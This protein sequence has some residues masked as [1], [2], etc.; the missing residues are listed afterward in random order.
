ML[1]VLYEGDVVADEK[2]ESSDVKPTRTARVKGSNGRYY[3]V[4]Y[5]TKEAL[6]AF[7]E[8]VTKSEAK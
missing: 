7:V 4:A 5:D 2:V 6:D 3:H 1:H 8:Q